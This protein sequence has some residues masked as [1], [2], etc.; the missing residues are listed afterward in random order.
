MRRLTVLLSM[1]SMLAACVSLASREGDEVDLPESLLQRING[2]SKEQ[3]GIK[4]EPHP[5]AKQ[6][7]YRQCMSANV[8]EDCIE[9]VAPDAFDAISGGPHYLTSPTSNLCNFPG[10][11]GQCALDAAGTPYCNAG[12]MYDGM[13]N[14]G[15]FT[16]WQ[17]QPIVG[18]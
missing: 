13:C 5:C 15:F 11:R 6:G 16:S 10:R 9:C 8:G 12:F 4:L 14:T 2:A 1:L 7:Q 18:E 3:K 17:E